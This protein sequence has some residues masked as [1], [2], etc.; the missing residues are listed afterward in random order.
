MKQFESIGNNLL[1]NVA[2]GDAA[3]LPVETKGA[4]YIAEKYGAINKL[5]APA[6]NPFYGG[7]LPAG[8]WSDDTQLSMTV[9]ASL[10]AAGDFDID[11]IARAHIE[12]YNETPEVVSGSGKVSKRGWGG[13]T[14][15]SIERIID[16]VSPLLAGEKDG[17]GNGVLMKLSPLVFWQTAQHVSDE[18]R[19]RQYDELTTMTHDSNVAR[20]CTR[21]HGDALQYLLQQNYDAAEFID[22][23][24][25]SAKRHESQLDAAF[26]TSDR[27]HYLLQNNQP[28]SVDILQQFDNTTS[29]FRYGFYAPETL[30]I[31]YGVFAA[32]ASDFQQAVFAA[33]NIGGD[34]DS[35]ASIVA[36][37]VHFLQKGE[38]IL[39]A[40]YNSVAELSLLRKVS[41]ELTTLALRASL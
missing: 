41:R 13:S 10:V 6:E 21:V 2:Y 11:V 28:T 38:Q 35:T 9:A 1:Q 30:A 19:Y 36:S 16:G 15:R 17:A 26:D 12:A 18:E 20:V 3:G 25:V 33:V 31:A 27:L 7:D 40:D 14:T 24:V 8:S 32:H 37:M 23:V 22:Y 5:L 29:G 39:P 34:S 4:G